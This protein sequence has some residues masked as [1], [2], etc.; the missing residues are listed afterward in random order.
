MEEQRKLCKLPGCD[1]VASRPFCDLHRRRITT[2]GQPG[3]VGYIKAPNRSITELVYFRLKLKGSS[4]EWDCWEWTGA[5]NDSGYGV[6]WVKGV[7]FYI[8][9]FVYEDM[10]AP[11]P[12]GLVLDHTCLN[13]KCANPFHLEPVTDE[14][15]KARGGHSSGERR[16]GGL[17][18]GN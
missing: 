8:H 12:A 17:R 9:R 4:L 2:T 18:S 6:V 13:R 16:W 14:E 11:I 10:I 15:N 7:F 1:R 5:L 3:P